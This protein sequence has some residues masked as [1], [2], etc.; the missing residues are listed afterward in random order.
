M[1]VLVAKCLPYL[2]ISEHILWKLEE[3]MKFYS[4]VMLSFHCYPSMIEAGDL[5][6]FQRKNVKYSY[7]VGGGNNRMLIE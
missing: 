6:K 3:M 4:H 2:M 1:D 7:F 5:P